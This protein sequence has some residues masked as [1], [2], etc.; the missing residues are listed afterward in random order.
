MPESVVCDNGGEFYAECHSFLQ[1]LGVRMV[2]TAVEAPWQ[3]GA[4]ERNG[5]EWKMMWKAVTTEHEVKTPD[6]IAAAC[7]M[8]GWAKNA[9][10]GDSGFS[11]AQLVLGRGMCL[12]WGCYRRGHAHNLHRKRLLTSSRVC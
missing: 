10:V 5:G 4:C 9:R 7:V 6:Q 8:I 2:Y 12:P 3:N 11:P 1:G